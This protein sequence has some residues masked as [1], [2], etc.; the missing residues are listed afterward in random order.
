MALDLRE[1]ER[2]QELSDADPVHAGAQGAVRP[3]PRGGDVEP[4]P[5]AGYLRGG[6]AGKLLLPEVDG[7]GDHAAAGPDM[8]Q[9]FGMLR[10]PVGHGHGG[11]AARDRGLF[12]GLRF[13]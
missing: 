2:G 7:D 13:R 12:Q 3:R 10:P 11:V 4:H 9:G 6:E 5:H 8:G 1:R